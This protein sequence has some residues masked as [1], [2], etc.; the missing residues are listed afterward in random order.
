MIITSTTRG[1]RISDNVELKE[2]ELCSEC[3]EPS[4][5]QCEHCRKFVEDPVHLH[6]KIIFS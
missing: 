2:I 3:G 5:Y 1:S 6:G 4:H